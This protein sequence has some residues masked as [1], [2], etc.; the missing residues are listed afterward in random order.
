MSGLDAPNAPPAHTHL[1]K[2]ALPP[3]TTHPHTLLLPAHLCAHVQPPCQHRPPLLLS[4]LA[5]VPPL[6]LLRADQQCKAT[7]G[8]GV[9]V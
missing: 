8:V 5:L 3:P 6:P 9:G 4:L 7:G 2:H 1:H